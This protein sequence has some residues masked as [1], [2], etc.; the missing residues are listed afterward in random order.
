VSGARLSAM[1]FPSLIAVALVTG[2]P[3]LRF[4]FYKT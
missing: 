4:D 1:A 3:S 2:L